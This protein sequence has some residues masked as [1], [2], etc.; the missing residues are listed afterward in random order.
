M[1][2]N[3]KKKLKRCI[4]GLPFRAAFIQ[5]LVVEIGAAPAD[6]IGSRAKKRVTI[7]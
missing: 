6:R 3:E 5:K 4:E 1:E 2:S 7:L